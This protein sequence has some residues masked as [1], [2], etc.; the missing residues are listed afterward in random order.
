VRAGSIP[1][2]SY[3]ND[4]ITADSVYGRCLWAVILIIKLLNLLGTY[5][6]LPKCHFLPNKK[7]EWLGFEIISEEELFRVS[8]KK[9]EKVKAALTQVLNSETITPRQLAA[10]A[11]KL[12]SLSPAVL[13]ASLF[14]RSL[15]QAIQGRISWDEIF[16]TPVAV[17]DTMKDWVENL[18]DW[19]GRQWYAKPISLLASS[20]ASDFGFGGLVELPNEKKVKVAG[21]LTEEEVGMSSTA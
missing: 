6:G 10:I 3:I 13:P 12:I 19:N 9:L 8:D 21:K 4:E 5:F 16:P 18:E 15:F 11:G 14:S 1:I 20:D 17:R 7:G 2:S